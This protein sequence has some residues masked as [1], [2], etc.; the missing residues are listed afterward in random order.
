MP[1]W[2]ASMS[3][4]CRSDE[5]AATQL[6]WNSGPEPSSRYGAIGPPLASVITAPPSCTHSA[7]AARS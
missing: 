1:R 7:A 6:M 2:T 5:A 3:I 4:V